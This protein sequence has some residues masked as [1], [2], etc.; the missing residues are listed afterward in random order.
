MKI[1]NRLEIL[2]T[3]L[4]TLRVEKFAKEIFAIYNI[5]CKMLF[6][7]INKKLLLKKKPLLFPK[8][9]RNKLQ[10]IVR[11]NMYFQST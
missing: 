2:R 1:K 4:V 5:D 7:N 8:K 10:K 11:K 3:A 6:H 9:T